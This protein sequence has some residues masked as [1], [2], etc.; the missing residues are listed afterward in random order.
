MLPSYVSL[1]LTSDAV[2]AQDLSII[3]PSFQ[4][5]NGSWFCNSK[6]AA[7]WGLKLVSE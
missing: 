1:E 7:R 2:M 4:K 5:I 6:Y 3:Y